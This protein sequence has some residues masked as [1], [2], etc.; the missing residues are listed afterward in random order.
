MVNAL[1]PY[2]S[3]ED[4]RSIGSSLSRLFPDAF[5]SYSPEKTTYPTPP[6]S[7]KPEQEFYFQSQQRANDL[8]TALDKMR[9][10]SGKE[11]SKFGP[12]Y[13]YLRQLATAMR[14]FGAKPGESQMTR[15]SLVRFY[16]AVDPLLSETKGEQLG[17]YG[18][19][20]RAITQPFFGANKL[21]NVFKDE[22][23]NWVFGKAN[24]GW[25]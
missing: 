2:L 4:Q 14:D 17:A 7:I 25:F 23:G 11:E 20:A 22:S 1:I 5:G 12:G 15:G 8:L 3:V 13:Q 24:T 6:T 18:E 21:V 16:S 9:A 19:I 10:A